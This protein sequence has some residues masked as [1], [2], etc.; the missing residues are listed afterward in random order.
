MT[1]PDDASAP[2]PSPKWSWLEPMTFDTGGVCQ[3]PGWL[4]GKTR[5]EI[6]ALSY[7]EWKALKRREANSRFAVVEGGGACERPAAGY[8]EGHQCG[9]CATE[10]G[11]GYDRLTK[12][13]VGAF[14][15]RGRLEGGSEWWACARCGQVFFRAG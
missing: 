13:R 10:L 6:D 4:R 8:I 12:I 1:H 15:C 14:V 3:E 2:Q 9:A 11:F 5:T 7:E